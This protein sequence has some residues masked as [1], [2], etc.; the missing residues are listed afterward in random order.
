M[1][2]VSILT[3][4]LTIVFIVH[5]WRKRRTNNNV[6]IQIV[7]F[8]MQV[9]SPAQKWAQR[10]HVRAQVTSVLDANSVTLSAQDPL[11]ARGSV[12]S[13]EVNDRANSGLLSV[14][15]LVDLFNFRPWAIE[16][17]FPSMTYAHK[18]YGL[19]ASPLVVFFITVIVPLVAY[20]IYTT[21]LAY[22]SDDVTTPA[23]AFSSPSATGTIATLADP[24]PSTSAPVST[25]R[26]TPHHVRAVS[27]VSTD[28]ATD[29]F[30]SDSFTSF[31]NS[32]S[33]EAA[34]L[35]K[36][37]LLV[38]MSRMSVDGRTL[39]R[40]NSRGPRPAVA[41][42]VAHGSHSPYDK[43]L[44]VCGFIINMLYMSLVQC[45][46]EMF[47]CE[48][49][50][51]GLRYVSAVPFLSC[52]SGEYQAMLVV[53]IL[54]TSVI[55]VILPSYFFYLLWKHR[56]I[57]REGHG[58]RSVGAMR[59]A[60]LWVGVRPDYYWWKTTVV[61][62][63]RLLLV[64]AVSLLHR[65]SIFIPV[66]VFFILAVSILMHVRHRPYALTVDNRLEYLLLG[67]A[68]TSYLVHIL[69]VR[70]GGFNGVEMLLVRAHPHCCHGTATTVSLLGL[71]TG[72]DP[73][74][75]FASAV[76]VHHSTRASSADSKLS[77]PLHQAR[78]CAECPR[79]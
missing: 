65:R 13:A 56:D 44:F 63:R 45:A 12:D 60:F 73:R 2:A 41:A 67:S 33:S 68:L 37:P 42:V 39:S 30:H 77:P 11:T 57:L 71:F 72:G 75:E 36:A 51:R 64:L 47:N 26:S 74:V 61:V 46:L 66:A 5:L 70:G 24:V 43:S 22:W 52:D 49:F 59:L 21:A 23:A 31:T 1:Y 15:F 20:K 34:A 29:A 48:E 58:E 54:V 79:W 14:P 10:C 40:P 27:G 38:P 76:F 32:P 3:P 19:M 9:A 8:W 4:L 78:R 50:G 18:F 62:N 55:G 16:C 17:V 7:L 35:L 25:T 69:A 6:T 28:S 53:A